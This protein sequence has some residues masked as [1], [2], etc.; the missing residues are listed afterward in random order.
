MTKNSLQYNNFHNHINDKNIQQIM[1]IDV[2]HNE[3]ISE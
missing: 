1:K 2:Y 3:S